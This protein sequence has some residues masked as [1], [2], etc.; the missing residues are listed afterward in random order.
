M[1]TTL[2]LDDALFAE[3][4]RRAA[5]EGVTMKAFIEQSLR[6]RLLPKPGGR[7]RFRLELPVVTGTAPPAVDISDRRSLYDFLEEHQ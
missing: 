7:K 4:K 5:R 1:K 6:A 2:E 3:I